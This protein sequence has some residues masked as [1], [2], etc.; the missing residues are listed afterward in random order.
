MVKL[1]AMV[2]GQLVRRQANVT[3]RRMQALVDAQ[4]R[5][6]AERLRLLEEEDAR[7]QLA[8]T[9]TTPRQ[10]PSRRSLRHPRSR[11][12]LVSNAIVNW[13]QCI[14]WEKI[15]T[16]GWVF[17][18]EAVERGTEES[19]KIVEVDDAGVAQGGRSS[20]FCYSTTPGRT[21]AKAELYQ[22]VS[23]TPSALTDVSART[24]SGRFDDASFSS[25]WEPPRRGNAAWRA[26][27]RAPA[28][29]ATASP[30]Y[31][32]NTES[33][34]A[35]ARSQSAPRQRHSSASESAA[36]ASP[37]PSCCEPR[38]PSRGGSGAARRRAS[39]DPLDLP[40]A[41]RSSAG[42][43]ERCAS[44][45]M[46]LVR[47]SVGAGASLPGSECG[48]SSTVGHRGSAQGAW[49]GWPSHQS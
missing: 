40:A 34:R 21:P 22:K 46:A 47:A 25:A 5:A 12:P 17:L 19:V 43:M 37:S 32:A 13:K 29:F 16:R 44:R 26:D 30:N 6:R 9:N 24:L 39:L 38:P 1:Q 36:A 49:H 31:M 11:K 23:P 27:H 35:K 7:H 42:R 28:P 41:P 20:S 8:N 2:R 14:W 33:S 4:R 45:A 10:P 18:Q 48:S 3:L 15:T